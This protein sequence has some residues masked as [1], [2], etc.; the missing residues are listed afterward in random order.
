M[1]KTKTIENNKENNNK[2][3]WH[4]IQKQQQMSMHL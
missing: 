2:K 1:G 4:Q 3:L